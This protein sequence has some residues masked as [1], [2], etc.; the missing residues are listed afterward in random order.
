MTWGW[1]DLLSCMPMVDAA[2][3]GRIAR[4]V[5]IFRVIRGLRA[6]KIIAGAVLV[7]RAENALLAAV[8]A[9]LLLVIFCSVAML[10]VEISPDSNI[11][12]AEDA[13]WWSLSTITTV[14]YGDRFPVT[15]EGR[16]IAAFLMLAGVAIF[17]TISGLLAALFLSPGR[18]EAS[19]MAA[20][21]QEISALRQELKQISRTGDPPVV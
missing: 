18:R 8:L 2:R 6:A 16:V 14:G 10:L 15:S 19:E 3:F 5:R 17:T 12:S 1:L 7:R 9:T 20:L 4:V 11:R 13:I 21:Q